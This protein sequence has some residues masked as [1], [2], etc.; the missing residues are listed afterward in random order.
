MAAIGAIRKHGV[1]LMLIIGIALL[2]FVV[3]DFTQ[4]AGMFS[5]KN[6]MV[7]INNEKL[8][9]QYRLLYDQ[10][11]ALWRI[12]YDKTSLE[13]SETYQIHGMTWEQ[14]FEEKILDEQLEKLG[15]VYSDE[16]I[17]NATTELVAS[18]RTQQ[19]NQL[20]YKLFT[21]IANFSSPEAAMS[22]ITNV[23][24]YK[25]QEGVRDLYNAFK[26]IERIN[27]SNAKWQSY[28]ALAQGSEYYSDKLLAKIAKENTIANIQF[29]SINPSVLAF[30]NITPTVTEKEIKEWYK[31]HKNRYEIKQDS[32]DIDVAIF[33]IAP[34][35]E[36]LTTIEDSVRSAYGRFLNASSIAEFNINEM[37]GPVDS[38][39][40]K[41]DD[42]VL[43]TL[44]SLVFSLPVGTFI[45]PFN[46]EN[47]AWYFGKVY[48]EAY[49][50]DSVQ[51]A[52]LVIDF[53]TEQ[54]L[55]SLRTKDEA[56]NVADSLKNILRSSPNAIFEMLPHYLGGRKAT[57]S[58]MWVPER[59]TYPELYDS[60]LLA[61]SQKNVYVNDNQ[62]AYVIFQPRKTTQLIQKR[63][64]VIY[65]TEIKASEKTLATIKSAANQLL[66]ESTS[67][68]AFNEAANRS[69]IQILRGNN[70]TS[71]MGSV[72]ELQN[73]RDIVSWTFNEDVKVG[74][75]SDVIKIDNRLYAVVGLRNINKKGIA[76]FDAVKST[77]EAEL[78]AQKKIE[79][80]EKMVV[81]EIN[82]GATIYDLANRYNSTV[83]DSVRVQFGL[84]FYQNSQI[85]NKAIAQIFSLPVDQKT[86]LVTG[87]QFLY[88]V[89]VSHKEESKPSEGLMYERMI[90][91]NILTNRSRN[92]MLII[93]DLKDKAKIHDNRFR[94]YQ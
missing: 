33:P 51:V 67:I 46:H 86:H 27:L 91:K 73:C 37:H 3:G 75:I 8:D 90:A 35:N 89:N 70:I 47:R 55:Q 69:G 43:E 1:L 92:E 36:D 34:S 76:P 32:R 15:L 39:Y 14:L 64:F 26:A 81:A 62:G 93:E 38:F 83:K 53:K 41:K 68:A 58:T 54:N 56:K 10:N 80:V 52:Y 24:D 66:A 48:G 7:R 79:E 59:S 49:R 42:I 63:L 21:S 13:E 29:A 94:F 22:F 23:E 78:I 44:D 6:T 57:D 28:F 25:N 84:D 11:T 61:Y 31:N 12:M 2:A 5:D 17:E 30:A 45:E 18:L 82:K 19:P 20:L 4:L 85:E 65:P 40:Y 50:P 16:M 87:K 88:L 72:N 9:D 71:M 74:N 60:L 77:I